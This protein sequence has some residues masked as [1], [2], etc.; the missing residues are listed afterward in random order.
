MVKKS[1]LEQNDGKNE[2]N[3]FN[4]KYKCISEANNNNTEGVYLYEN[5]NKDSKASESK[6]FEAWEHSKSEFES[7]KVFK[8]TQKYKSIVNVIKMKNLQ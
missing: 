1:K 5:Y 4:K 2:K 3:N 6:V 8:T 7:E